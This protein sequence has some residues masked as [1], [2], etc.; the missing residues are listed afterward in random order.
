MQKGYHLMSVGNDAK[1]VKG[2][3]FGY[4]TGLVYLAPHTQSGLGNICP[5]ASSGCA[6]ACLYTAGRGAMSNVKQARIRKTKLFL[7]DRLGFL[8]LLRFDLNLLKAEAELRGLTPCVRLNGTSDIPW[9]SH[10]VIEEHPELQFYDYTKSFRRMVKYVNGELPRNYHLTFSRSEINGE[11]CKT[12]LN[13]GANVAVVFGRELPPEYH[14]YPVVNGDES[15]LRFLDGKN[16]VVGLKAK[17]S[18]KS[19]SNGFVVW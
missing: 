4:I 9:E 2:E 15:D 19:E 10:G 17:G 3:R 5:W 13:T 16:V 14:G 11:H 6:A 8:R 1:T 12:V 7:T 18:A